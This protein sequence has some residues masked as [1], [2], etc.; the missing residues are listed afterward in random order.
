[1]SEKI[2]AGHLEVTVEKTENKTVVRV[3]GDE[4]LT[5]LIRQKLQERFG[6]GIVSV[7]IGSFTLGPLATETNVTSEKP[8]NGA[9]LK[10]AVIRI[11]ENEAFKVVG[12]AFNEGCEKLMMYKEADIAAKL[13]ERRGKNDTYK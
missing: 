13:D 4:K 2:R 8:H 5:A 9:P 12:M 6:S 1:M 7:A 11:L 3:C 10:M